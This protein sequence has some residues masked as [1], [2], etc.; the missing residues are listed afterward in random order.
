MASCTLKAVMELVLGSEEFAPKVPVYM[1]L[2][3]YVVSIA[4][5]SGIY[6]GQRVT[7]DDGRVSRRHEVPGCVDFHH[8]PR[9]RP[10]CSS[11]VYT[12]QFQLAQ[13]AVNVCLLAL[14]VVM[15]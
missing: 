10:A 5:A 12:L 3:F 4:T 2:F 15:R 1:L 8:T 14:Y 11:D 6:S 13:L 9:C 7:A